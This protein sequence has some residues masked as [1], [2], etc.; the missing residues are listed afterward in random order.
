MLRMGR[1]LEMDEEIDRLIVSVRADTGA[2]ARDVAEMRGQLEGPL[3]AGVERAG[4]VLENA[5]VRAVTTGK[6]G[7][8]DLKRVAL[9][10]L[11]EIAQAAIRNGLNS[12]G[13]GGSGGGSGGTGGLI[14]AA[15]QVLST[16]LGAPGR[17]TGGPVSPGARTWSASAGRSCS[18]RRQAGGWKRMAAAAVAG[19]MFG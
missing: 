7:F 2:F 6:F 13:G 10:A 4:R 19:A 11:A 5:L 15:A 17:A 16:F 18:C 12:L 14:S 1:N 8:E 9:A 3:A